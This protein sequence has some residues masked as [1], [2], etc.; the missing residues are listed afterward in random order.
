MTHFIRIWDKPFKKLLDRLVEYYGGKIG[1]SGQ[2]FGP[3]KSLSYPYFL[4][5]I[6]NQKAM[7]EI[8][9]FPSLKG[10]GGVEGI[11]AIQYLRIRFYFKEKKDY[12]IHIRYERFGDKFGKRVHW[13]YEFQ[14]R[15]KRFDDKYFIELRTDNDKKLISDTNLQEMIFLLEPFTIFEI[16]NTNVHVAQEIKKEEQLDFNKVNEY[17]QRIYKLIQYIENYKS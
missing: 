7:V 5:E 9:E 2:D 14:T 17:I 16:K 4:G 13:T 6:N 12:Y 15:H 8:S 10:V 11:D 1:Y 3:F